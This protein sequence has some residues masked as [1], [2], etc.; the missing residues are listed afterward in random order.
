[1]A[2]N[3]SGNIVDVLNKRIFPGK[4]YI[5]DSKINKIEEIKNNV[6]NQFILPGLIDAHVHIES[7]MLSPGGFASLAVQ[8]GTIGSVSD[9]HEIANVMGMEG[10]EYMI[11]DGKKVPF[12]FY[13][14]APSCVPATQ[15]ETSGA[16]LGAN[17]IKDLLNR[18]EVKYLSEMMNFPGVIGEDKEVMQKIDSAKKLNKPI[19]GHA[20]GLRGEALEKYIH[21]GITTDHECFTIE[22]AREKI[23][24]GMMV[25]IR[26]GS[27]AR[28]FKALYPLISEYP[29]K[30]MLCS[31]D[32][33]PDD[34]LKGHINRL[35]V[36]GLN[37]GLDL[38]DI[39]TAAIITPKNHYNLDIG[40]LQENDPADLI[41]IDNLKDFRIKQVYINGELV[42]DNAKVLF[43]YVNTETINKFVA[44]PVKKNE[45]KV[46]AKGD[47]IRVIKAFDGELITG[48]EIVEANIHNDEV[49]PDPAYDI[50]KVVVLN[51][52]QKSNPV[53]GFITGFGL[54]KGALA[55]SI[56]H[57]SHNII[58]MGTNDTDITKV[59]NKVIECRG[60][61]A[62]YDGVNLDTIQLKIAGLM[63]DED[64]QKVAKDY[65][66]IN[67]K[68]A[69][70][71]SKI[72][73]PFMTLAFMSLLVI[74]ELKIGDKGL[75]NVVD[76][77]ETS[78]FL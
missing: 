3:I 38:F 67:S 69:K 39:L 15:Y 61:I 37:E 17:E 36:E 26:E 66:R 29:G 33:H 60:G 64:P 56:A 45:L 52:Y 75:F 34:L 30:V 68:A 14:G 23:E 19:D 1:M 2:K 28:N 63:S 50:Q 32:L 41:V 78:L 70:L 54:E 25:Q 8:H 18:D 51:R 76:F 12:K 35:I 55:S 65:E 40:L 77:K 5:K 74:P 42:V 11:R 24:H 4:I 31:D 46:S 53:V 22:E 20:P 57:D 58:A 47:K 62:V 49:F 13:F 27:A 59:L 16:V 9:P 73:S 7:S 10:V 72:K 43:D 44:Q 71:C 6:P 48:Q 21:A